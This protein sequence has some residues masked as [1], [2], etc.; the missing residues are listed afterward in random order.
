M[1]MSTAERV[2]NQAEVRIAVS[3]PLRKETSPMAVRRVRARRA[4]QNW[5]WNH[6]Q[7]DAARQRWGVESSSRRRSSRAQPRHGHRQI[8]VPSWRKVSRYMAMLTS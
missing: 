4:C 3:E 1:I 8:W 7:S 2:P 5:P 6:I